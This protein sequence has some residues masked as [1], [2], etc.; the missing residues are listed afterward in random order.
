MS[1]PTKLHVV[2]EA[3]TAPAGTNIFDDLEKVRKVP[4]VQIARK[5]IIVN[6]DVGKPP[7]D[8]YF[9]GNSDPAWR[10]EDQVVVPVK[11]SDELFY[12]SPFSN[13]DSHPKLKQRLRKVTLVTVTTWPANTPRIWPLPVL[14]QGKKDCKAWKS[15]RAAFELSLT[16]WTQMCW[17]ETESNYNIEVAEGLEHEPIWPELGFSALLKMAFDGKII[18]SEDHDFVRQLRGIID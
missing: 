13:M 5:T 2:E 6:V 17:N 11:D 18:E 16:K 4:K 8:C 3:P 9:R 10:L 1:E 15:A 12:I 14:G 7:R